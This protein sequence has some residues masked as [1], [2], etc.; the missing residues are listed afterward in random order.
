MVRRRVSVTQFIMGDPMTQSLTPPPSRGGS[1]EIEAELAVLRDRLRLVDEIDRQTTEMVERLAEAIRSS[2]EVRA[3]ANLEIGSS[4]E[5]LERVLTER[6]ARHR[7]TVA[8]LRQ[9]VTVV[10]ARAIGLGAAVTGL[11]SN[12][13]G[14]Q[15]RLAGAEVS[16]TAADTGMA[17]A[18][19]PHPVESPLPGPALGVPMPPLPSA[20]SI[21]V[22]V[23]RVPSAGAAL[24]IQ[25]FVSELPAVV[26]ATTRE[27]SSSHLRLEIRTR[28]P[29]DVGELQRWPEGRLELVKQ[30]VDSVL[31][32][33]VE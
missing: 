12:L 27:F 8:A 10:H 23:E 5:R 15:A 11:E 20:A 32:R 7:E 18:A 16:A 26:A 9:D 1:G 19:E 33:I 17:P 31:L 24:S 29:I 2:A 21:F 4:L 28:G 6:E 25:R 30:D 3:Q 14:L 13:A 22:E